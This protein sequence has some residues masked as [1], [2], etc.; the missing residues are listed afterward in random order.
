MGFRSA[1]S[2]ATRK[3]LEKKDNVT[4]H[5]SKSR[6]EAPPQ[7]APSLPPAL[8]AEM[9]EKGDGRRSAAAE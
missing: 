3:E 8:G 5:K 2:P 1:A 9:E 7:A 4:A 6:P